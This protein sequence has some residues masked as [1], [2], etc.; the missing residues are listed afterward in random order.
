VRQGRTSKAQATVNRVNLNRAIEQAQALGADTME[1]GNMDAYFEVGWYR[2]NRLEQSRVSIRVPSNFHFKMG[3]ETYLRVQPNDQPAY[4]LLNVYNTVNSKVSGGNLVGDRYEHTYAPVDH[5][6]GHEFGSVIYVIGAHDAVIENVEAYHATGEGLLIHAESIRNPDGT[7][8]LGIETTENLLVKG[9]I[10]RDN[11]RNNIAV[12][13]ADGVVFDDIT[14]LRAGEGIRPPGGADSAAGVQP[15]AAI[16]LEATRTAEDGEIN[17][18]TDITIRNSLIRDNVR[19]LVVHTP[20]N[21]LIEKNTFI[22]DTV[23]SRASSDVTVQDNTFTSL[24]DKKPIAIN[25]RRF[26]SGLSGEQLVFEWRVL[27]NT[28]TGYR[29]AIQVGGDRQTV[30]GN[31]LYENLTGIKAG[32][33]SDSVI[34]DNIIESDR[35]NSKGHYHRPLDFQKVNAEMADISTIELTIED[36][37]L[38]STGPW[39]VNIANSKNIAIRNSSHTNEISV[40][41]SENIVLENNSPIP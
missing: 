33:L 31:K 14:V 20:T 29:N 41:A 35:P 30:S 15:W 3:D 13:D 26:V 22:N 12:V 40:N 39:P 11:R 17:K 2:G 38:R 8:P 34:S 23:V 24:N 21:V 5:P 6:A 25:I 27:R 28:I 37:D 1:F 16:D 18:I 7:L 4:S 36:S 32:S 10:Y 9:G 19:G